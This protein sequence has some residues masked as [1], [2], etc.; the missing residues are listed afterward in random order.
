MRSRLALAI[1]T[2]I[3]LGAGGCRGCSCS[4]RKDRD[5]VDVPFSAIE[6]AS[7][8]SAPPLL[9]AVAGAGDGAASGGQPATGPPGE[10]L[11]PSTAAPEGSGGPALTGLEDCCS[12]LALLTKSGP[13][14]GARA[15]YAQAS[16]LCARTM[17]EVR[18][19]QLKKGEGLARVRGALLGSAP[20]SCR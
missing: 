18:R 17:R 12:M 11:V 6:P 9:D 10:L 13:D 3:A 15:M 14:E 8:T 5:P 19:G 16:A 4:C 1:L 7:R 2:A 20:A